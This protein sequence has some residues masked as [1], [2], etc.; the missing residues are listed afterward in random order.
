MKLCVKRIY[1]PDCRK[2]VKCHEKPADGR[3]NIVCASCG[4]VIWIKNPVTWRYAAA[5]KTAEGSGEAK[6]AQTIH[7]RS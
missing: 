3:I 6:V 1:C 4:G 7:E 5:G 2:L